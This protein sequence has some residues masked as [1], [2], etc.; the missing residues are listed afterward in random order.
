MAD[1]ITVDGTSVTS[2]D[3]QSLGEKLGRFAQELSPAE[4]ALFE[5]A[6][7]RSAPT[8]EESARHIHEVLPGG[9]DVQ[10]YSSNSGWAFQ[11]SAIGWMV[12]IY[13]YLG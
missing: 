5:A 6:M 8:N 12:G 4:K 1:A 7:R 2:D 3:I 13:S 10:G 11:Q 9:G